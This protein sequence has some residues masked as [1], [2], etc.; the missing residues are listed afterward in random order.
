MNRNFT[1][2]A[3]V[4]LL[5]TFCASVNAQ[6]FKRGSLLI[7]ISEGYTNGNYSTT[8]NTT[9]A[10]IARNTDGNRD[11]LTVEYGLTKHWGVGI[12][13]GGDIF[14]VNPSTYYGF[15]AAGKNVKVIT[16]EVTADVHYHFFVTRHTD[17]SSFAS[18]GFSGVNIKGSS[19]DGSYQYNASGNIARVGAEAR[20]YFTRHFGV[21]GM[22]SV[23][24]LSCSTKNV[25]GNTVG[26]DYSTGISGYALE[27]GFC[28]RLLR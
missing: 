26:N 12:N 14:N 22:G 3:G 24:S 5:F 8:N 11:P 17:L 1:F 18:F 7:S 20:Y 19:G 10:T 15:T 6:S 28:F 25:K 23:Y 4:L 27:F 21:L 2:A 13:L 9:D 16:S